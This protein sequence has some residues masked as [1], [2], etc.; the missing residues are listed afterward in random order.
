MRS[1]LHPE[2]LIVSSLL[3][4]FWHCRHRGPSQ[5]RPR[6]LRLYPVSHLH[7]HYDGKQG[8]NDSWYVWAP[9]PM[10]RPADT[11]ARVMASAARGATVVAVRMAL[12]RGGQRRLHPRSQCRHI[13]LLLLK[14][15]TIV[16]KKK[17]LKN[18]IISNTTLI[19][20]SLVYRRLFGHDD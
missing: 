17:R 8:T 13:G 14:I 9:R 11:F 6:Q 19:A 5:P 1:F 10:V 18:R 7:I 4:D 12:S 16:S 3:A 2:Y 15:S 20:Y